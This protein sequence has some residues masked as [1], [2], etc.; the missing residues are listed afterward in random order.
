MT[1][2]QALS[3]VRTQRD[4]ALSRALAAEAQVRALDAAIASAQRAGNVRQLAELQKTRANAAQ[5]A[6]AARAEASR[7]RQAALTGLGD[8]LTQTPE[9]IVAAC[10]ADY[11]FVL[12]PVRLETKFGPAAAGGTELR[13]RIFPDDI[14]LA[15]PPTPLSADETTAGQNYW[16][17][18]V[19][20]KAAPGDDTLRNAYQGA[21]TLVASRFGAWRAGYIVGSTQ[22][23]DPT[24]APDALVFPSAPPPTSPPLPRADALPDRFVVLTYTTDSAQALV[25]VNR[26]V[27]A[28][29]PDDLALAPD[30]MDS[31]SWFTRDPVTGRISVPDGLKWLVDFDA[32]VAAGMAV[33]VPVAPPYDANGFARVVA[34]GLRTATPPAEGP[35][36]LENLLAKHRFGSGCAL[37]PAGTP[38]NNTESVAAGWQ[39]ASG[40]AA[41]LFELE[42]SPPD[43]SPQPGVLGPCDGWRLA[44][45]L[46]LSADFS[47]RLPNATGTDIAEALAMNRAAVPGTLDNFVGIFLKTLVDSPTAAGLHAFFNDWVSGR[48]LYPALRVGRQPYGVV[49]TSAWKTWQFPATRPTRGGAPEVAPKI[50]QLIDRHRG[51]WEI[52]ARAAPH[53]ALATAD[54]FQRLL[55]IVGLL[56]SSTEF[57]SRKAMS[58]ESIS[59]RLGFG[60]ASGAEVRSWFATL[61]LQRTQNLNAVGFPPVSGPQDP[62]VAFMVFLDAIDEWPLPI[63]DRDPTVPLSE[64]AP[65]APF[66]GSRNY[67]QWLGQASR[68]DLSAE[69]FVDAQGNPLTRPAALLYVLLRHALLAATEGTSLDLAQQFG[70]AQFAVLASDPLISNIGS[71]QH[72]LRKDYLEVD[73]AK[74][75][76]SPRPVALADWALANARLEVSA[77][78]ASVANLSEVHDAIAALAPLPTA[79]LERLLAEHLDLCSYRLDAWITGIYSQRLD[80]L[81][82]A[83]PSPGIHLGA[84]GWVENLRPAGAER[85]RIAPETLPDALRDAAGPNLFTEADNGG[86]VHAPSLAQ[87]ASA[88]VLRNAYLSHAN[89]AQPLPFAVN[90]S[91]ARMRQAMTLSQG[92]RGGQPLGALLG[93]QLERGLHEGYSGVELDSTI[94]ALRDQFPLVSGRLNDLPAGS[95]VETIEARNVVDGLGLVE[96]TKGKTY[97][98][99]LTGLPAAGSAA[100]TAV[101]AEIDK[102]HD[103]LDAVSDLLLAESVHQAVQGNTAR[104]QASLQALTGPAAPPEPEVIRTP[105]SGT[106]LTFRVALA[107]DAQGSATWTPASSPRA[108]ANPQLNHWLAGR[109]PPPA[110]IQWTTRAMGGPVTAQSFAAL[111]LEPI[112]LVLMSGDR[113]GD[114]SGELERFLVRKFRWDN[115]VADEISTVILPTTAPVDPAVSVTFDF[116]ATNGGVAFAA[117]HPLLVRL[118]RIITQARPAHAGDWRRAADV[119]LADPADPTGSASGDPRLVAF[120]DLTSRLD[121]ATAALAAANNNLQV[122][123]TNAGPL[124]AG[125]DADPATIADPGWPA[126]LDAL[127]VALFALAPFGIPEAVPADGVTV[128]AALVAKLTGQAQAV[129]ALVSRRMAVAAPLRA[130]AFASPLPPD[131]P[132]RSGESARRNDTLRAAYLEAARA[133]LG[134]DFVLVPLFQFPTPQGGELAQAAAA[135]AVTDPHVLDDWIHSVSRVRA[136]VGDLNWAMAAARW[137]GLPIGDPLVLQLPFQAGAPWIGASYSTDLPSAECLSLVVVNSAMLGNALQC[138][139]LIDDWT[140]TVPTRKET[141]GVSFNLNRPNA[142]A[143]Q[144]ILVAVPPVVGGN[145]A[146]NDLIASVHE[147][148]DLARMRAV[149]PDTLIGRK[150]G[151]SAP[152]GNYF[153]VL[154][155]LLSEFSNSRLATIDYAA[156]VNSLRVTQ[157]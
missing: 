125:L 101:A 136:P 138:G 108:R 89:S 13:V 78:P 124:L 7:F 148:L 31:E 126:L 120:A 82:A 72:V 134:T 47:R 93:Y 115:A 21:W 149:E 29:I 5:A 16:R 141:T 131:E 109:L 92:V 121:A 14:A 66:D 135:P 104:T 83:Q 86:Y 17:A 156:R 8:W 67:L 69:R 11:P 112:D 127:R 3:Q 38:T 41:E 105:R 64:N 116:G 76:L 132:A 63:V 85:Q 24:A 34:I 44:R 80:Q 26:I 106:V 50:F 73:A 88:A 150:A 147:A 61:N 23:Q 155:A 128:T 99:G 139:L 37:V 28:P 58:D 107:L 32:A 39:P 1:T 52:L 98:F 117:I 137:N 87:A 59:H 27:G 74:I 95:A 71:Q 123:L 114:Q 77:R 96:A 15:T 45:L 154:P 100:A 54:P 142:T 35:A 122:A 30:A 33:R 119:A 9:Q 53:A 91:S 10:S 19:A 84:F 49:V 2:P 113:L 65:I 68:A 102:L 146:W 60:G 20:A 6:T 110:Q 57:A 55:G 56:A 90:L 97:P 62:L 81:V 140:E 70:S 46:G 25:E 130:T 145:W 22:P 151:E 103:A 153:Q 144:A 42:D 143:P 79:R 4:A 118:R 152:A 12:L 51:D 111:G 129:Q 40:D 36:T 75:G 48:G 94:Y 133:L 43:L 157:P 18:R